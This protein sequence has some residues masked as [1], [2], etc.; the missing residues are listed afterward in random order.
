MCCM[1]EGLKRGVSQY[2]CPLCG[3]A[4]GEEYVT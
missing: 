2:R 1:K 3:Q 4:A